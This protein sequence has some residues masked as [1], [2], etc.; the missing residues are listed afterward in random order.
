MLSQLGKVLN[1]YQVR[2]KENMAKTVQKAKECAVP[3][4]CILDDKPN[5]TIE[6]VESTINILTTYKCPT[7]LGTIKWCAMWYLGVKSFRLPR[8]NIIVSTKSVILKTRNHQ[9]VVALWKFLSSSCFKIL[10]RSSSKVNLQRDAFRWS[11]NWF[12]SEQ[13]CI[14]RRDDMD[15]RRRYLQL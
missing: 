14:F 15:H 7:H 11:I 9:H 5:H 10:S 12:T 6:W 3:S 8:S 13:N 1:C 4:W 2:V